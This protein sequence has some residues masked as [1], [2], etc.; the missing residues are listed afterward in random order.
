MSISFKLFLWLFNFK[1][2]W[3]PDDKKILFLANQLLDEA[4]KQGYDTS[5][6]SGDLF[7]LDV[8]WFKDAKQNGL[9]VGNIVNGWKVNGERS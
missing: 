1:V 3:V 9:Q 6:T 4:E 7:G 8:D 2:S 5:P